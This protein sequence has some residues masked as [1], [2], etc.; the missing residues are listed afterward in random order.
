MIYL[1]IPFCKQACH[2][3]NFHF[4]TSLKYKDDFVTALLKEI[5]LRYTYLADK[6]IETI[7]FGGG[8]PSL[9]SGNEINRIIGHLQKYFDLSPTI[10][11]TLE[12][13]PDDLSDKKVSE[14]RQTPINRFSIGIQSFFDA[15]LRYMN[16]AHTA[17]EADAS[18]KRVQ[19]AGFESLTIDLIYGTPTMTSSQWKTNLKKAI[20]LQVP[21][22][23]AYCLTVEPNT[24]LAHFV[25]TGK[26]ADVNEDYAAEQFETM[27]ETLTK[28]DFIHY[29]ISNFCK[30]GKESKHNS[31]YWL[32]KHYLGLGPSAHSFNGV[33]RQWNVAHNAQYIQSILKKEIPAEIEHLTPNQRFNE[34]LMTSLRTIWGCDL[35]K[36]QTDFGSHYV[37]HL[38]PLVTP[39]LEKEILLKKED[40]LT[41]STKGRFLA[42]GVISDLMVV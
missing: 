26:A 13:N 41:L 19:D 42:D 39:F 15:D 4:S 11:I 37:D 8:T 28:N 6:K 23:S 36:V 24:A 35:K 2:Y 40:T 17:Q 10:E 30:K 12:A 14:F 29:E 38:Q 16:R 32:G 31:G 1:H 27:V 5:D 20:S 22:I 9:L 18:I 34:Y 21:H 3:C 25:K 33:S 7:Y